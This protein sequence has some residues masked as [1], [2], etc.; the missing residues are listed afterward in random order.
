VRLPHFLDNQLTAGSEAVSLAHRE[1]FTPEEGRFLVLISVSWVDPR[2]VVICNENYDILSLPPKP[3]FL[4]SPPWR[5]VIIMHLTENWYKIKFFF[6]WDGT[7]PPSGNFLW[8]VLNYKFPSCWIG[9]GSPI[10]YAH[11][12]NI[13]LSFLKAGMKLTSEPQDML[14]MLKYYVSWIKKN[15]TLC[16]VEYM[17]AVQISRHSIDYTNIFTGKKILKSRNT[18]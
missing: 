2:A 4:L 6:Q 11:I 17:R 13:W 18:I 10:S 1:S 12:L 16:S 8:D 15:T 3:F 5:G 7:P 9:R 14:I